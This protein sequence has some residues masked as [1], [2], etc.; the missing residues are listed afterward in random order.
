ME[1]LM[2]LSVVTLR[3]CIITLIIFHGKRRSTEWREMGPMEV[4]LKMQ[5]TADIGMI[6]P[7]Q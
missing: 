1:T 6:M 3:I 4:I 5:L 2:S 7:L